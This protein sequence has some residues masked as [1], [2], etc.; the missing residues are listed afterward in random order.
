MAVLK[1]LGTITN[2]NCIHEEIKSRLNLGNASY[3]SVQNLLSSPFLSK[4]IKII[5]YKSIILPS[6]LYGCVTWFS[7]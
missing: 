2:Q 4:N 1:Y 6:V 3:Y 7:H 5:M